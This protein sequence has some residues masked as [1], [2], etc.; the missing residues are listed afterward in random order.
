[1]LRSPLQ[2]RKPCASR[3]RLGA[4][5][6]AAISWAMLAAGPT[7]AV[8]ITVKNDSVSDFAQVAVQL[9]FVINE[10]GAA[11]LTS[12][13]GGEIVAVQIY[14]RSASGTQP[15]VAGDLIRI[16]AAGTFPVPGAQLALLPAPLMNDNF[17]NEFRYLD[18]A[19]TIP[20]AVPVSEG[21]VFVVAFRFAESPG[22]S[23]PSLVTDT[24]GCQAGKNGIFA[25]PPS[26]WFSSCI[27]GVSGDFVI[28]AIVDCPPLIFADGFEE[29]DFLA[30]SFVEP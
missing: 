17:L 24:D 4:L 25:I 12:P 6:L 5:T 29:G 28:R 22:L 30:W 3:G 13:C 23:D 15:D 14:W 1:M 21:Q 20:L 9:G 26:Q 2:V 27:F 18:E 11:W 7:R 8:E 19:G 10:L 16:S